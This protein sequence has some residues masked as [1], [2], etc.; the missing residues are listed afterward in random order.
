VTLTAIGYDVKDSRVGAVEATPAATGT[1][2]FGAVRY[3]AGDVWVTEWTADSRNLRID[4][5]SPTSTISID[6]VGPSLGG[7]GR[8]EI[9]GADGKLLGRYTT[10]FLQAAAVETMTLSVPTSQIAYAIVRSTYES[11]I[12]V[13]N[14]R[15]GP[16]STVTTDASGAYALPYLPPGSYHV[17][18]VPSSDWV[19]ADPV[20]GIRDVVVDAQ[21]AMVWE[22][23]TSRPSDFVGRPSPAAPPWH[24]PIDALDV[25]DDGLLSPIDALLVI[26][27]LNRVGAHLLLPPTGGAAPPPYLDVTGDNFVSAADALWVINELNRRGSGGGTLGLTGSGGGSGGGGGGGQAESGEGEAWSLASE[28]A[29]NLGDDVDRSKPTE[30]DTPNPASNDLRSGLNSPGQY[31]MAV[32]EALTLLAVDVAHARRTLADLETDAL[33]QDALGCLDHVTLPDI[34]RHNRRHRLQ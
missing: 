25:N 28:R 29:S 11:T 30:G 22:T 8:L 15:V 19:V 23:G 26:N 3:G 24:N 32:E 12:R 27:E 13:D 6:A 14:L 4:V 18:A 16:A 2:V 9:Y 20:S 5:D 17:R 10:K 33:T 21:G 7:Y 1:K 34:A 31:P